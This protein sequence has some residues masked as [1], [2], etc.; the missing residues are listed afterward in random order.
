MKLIHEKIRAL[1][2]RLQAIE[3]EKSALQSELANAQRELQTIT[4]PVVVQPTHSFSA[5]EKIKLFMT[6]FRGRTEVFP[7]R[8][9]NA[10]SGKSGYS[11]ACFNEWVAGK[12]YKPKI[13]CSDCVNQA[14]MPVT[15][16]SIRQHLS[17]KN[18]SGS[19]KDY[20]LGVYPLLADDTCWFLAIDFDKSHW[21]RDVAA[22]MQTCRQKS[23]PFSL[24]RSRSGQGGHIWIFFEQ[25]M[26]ATQARK[27]GS[28]LLTETMEHY[29]DIGFESYDRL[30]PSQDTLPSGGFGNLIALPLQ[31]LPRTQ[32][33]SVFLDDQFEPYADQWHYL[34]SVSKMSAVQINAI[35]EAAANQGKILGVRL[36]LLDE[37]E[38]P[39]EMK[40]SR[41]VT[42]LPM[43]QP[44]PTSVTLVLSNQIFIPKK[45]LPPWLI[46]KL[47]RLAA[48]QNPEF[49]AAQALRLST[50]GKPRIVACAED[51]PHYMG[52]PRGCWD[53]VI[54][55]FT[56]L[57]IE[58]RIEDKR[59][60]GH[61]LRAKFLGK[62]TPEQKKAAKACLH[63]DTGVLAATTAFGKTVMGAYLISKRKTNTLVIVHR[64]QLLDQWVAQLK[65]FL[66]LP[67]DHIG[68][69]GGGKRNLTR[70]V[71]VAIMQSLVKKNTVDDIVA[72]YGQIIIDECHHVSAVSFEAVARASKAKY[73]LG[74][75]ATATRKDGHHPIIFMQCGP[76]RY[77]VDA[78]KQ[79][80]LRSFTH[81][82][83]VRQTP[84]CL[85]THDTSKQTINAIYATLIADEP[86]N[87][88]I[89]SDVLKALQQGRSPL[90]LTERKA[91]ATYFAHYFAALCPHV[92]VMVGGQ[93]LKQR[94]SVKAQLHA[95]ADQAERLLIATG[96][97]IGEGF[98]DARLDTLFLTLP[99]SWHGTLAQ[100]A[101]RLHRHH[102][103]KKTV[104][105]YDYVDG[106]VP[107]LAKMSEKRRQ[108]YA[109]IGYEVV[110]N[111]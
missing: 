19:Q 34:A 52:L 73:S 32:G 93:S 96:R 38:K 44:L 24:E 66:D 22:F 28:T 33:N 110:S 12:C 63:Y 69:L 30:F 58:V 18:Q 46:T 45:D 70:Q 9:E 41:Q 56:A 57:G 108:G 39:W 7:R 3:A 26:P 76:I 36:P 2:T 53:D 99:I 104:M 65:L 74:L 67:E 11:P 20:T 6:L 15:A 75:T 79:A 107:M 16:Q 78:K 17:G 10:K 50:W 54:A 49:Y 97:Y 83:I 98:D 105:I 87:Q 29:P 106:N 94:L 68:M 80:K 35:V 85:R 91:H 61:R 37:N 13:K 55:L 100:Y 47:M 72:E 48:F 103:N 42:E 5:E 95:I 4:P 92:V 81:Q 25:A 59:N 82:V 14:F 40:P 27:L 51:F 23:I 71:D 43:D 64:R 109:K 1:N 90:L 89:C 88:L 86:R 101:G 102:H 111:T 31:R 60:P 77:R 84:F 8:W 21:Q 62:L